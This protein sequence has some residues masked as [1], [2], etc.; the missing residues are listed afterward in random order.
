MRGPYDE[1]VI[2]QNCDRQDINKLPAEEGAVKVAAFLDE[3]RLD[4]C[5]DANSDDADDQE[6][7]DHEPLNVIRDEGDAEAAERGVNCCNEGFD[8]EGGE[9]IQ[10]C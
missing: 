9:A 8:D 5:F 10:A 2:R 6:E 7:D 3:V 4:I 1:K